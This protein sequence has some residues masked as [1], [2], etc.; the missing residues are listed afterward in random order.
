MTSVHSDKAPNS[1]A[2]IEAIQTIADHYTYHSLE[3]ENPP[4]IDW[5]DWKSI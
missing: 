4:T 1:D 3:G 5:I 2:L